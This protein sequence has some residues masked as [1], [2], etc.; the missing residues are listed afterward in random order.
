[1]KTYGIAAESAGHDDDDDDDDDDDE[2]LDVEI[3]VDVDV[4]VDGCIFM[5]APT[6]TIIHVYMLLCFIVFLNV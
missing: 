6:Y 3:D 4:D 5:H 1:M 2:D